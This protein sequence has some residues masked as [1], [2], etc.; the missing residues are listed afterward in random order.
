MVSASQ[1]FERREVTRLAEVHMFETLVVGLP[2]LGAAELT[3][4]G[5]VAIV[6]GRMLLLRS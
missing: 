4:S 6:R 3:A 2:A 5:R 1:F